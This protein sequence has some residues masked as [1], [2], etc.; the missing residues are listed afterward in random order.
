MKTG[1]NFRHAA[2]QSNM[3]RKIRRGVL[4]NETVTDAGD[5]LSGST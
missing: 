1:A 5:R 3:P 2:A 4:P